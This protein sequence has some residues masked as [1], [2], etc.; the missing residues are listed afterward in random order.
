MGNLRKWGGPLSQAWLIEQ[1]VLQ[2]QI[3][4][5]MLRLGMTPVLPTF[6]GHVPPEMRR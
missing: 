1:K 3:L 4:N 6:A 2:K 5:R